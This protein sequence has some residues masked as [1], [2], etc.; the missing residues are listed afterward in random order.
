MHIKIRIVCVVDMN[1]ELSYLLEELQTLIPHANFEKLKHLTLA[2][3]KER[4][5]YSE[6]TFSR[7]LKLITRR[8]LEIK[9]PL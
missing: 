9:P 3:Q 6:I 1:D 7:V 4:R 5:L 8:N 2:I